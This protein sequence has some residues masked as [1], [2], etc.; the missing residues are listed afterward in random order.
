M[1]RVR[2]R[3][4]SRGESRYRTRSLGGASYLTSRILCDDLAVVLR[5]FPLRSGTAAGGR[6]VV[7]VHG[8]GTSSRYFRPVAAEL[9]K[10]SPVYIVDL[11]GYGS[12]PN[13]RRDVS[14]AD[15]AGVLAR[16]LTAER[17]ENPVLVGHSMGTQVVTRLAFDHPEVT[18]KLVMRGDNDCVSPEAWSREV[19]ALCR[20]GRYAVVR[21]PHVIMYT[22]PVRT[23][24]LIVAH[25]NAGPA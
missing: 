2:R 16:F 21:G 17:I 1:A 13:P 3:F 6:P 20:D 5:R 9:A 15:H 23:A 25:A 7:L 18:D 12:A 8:L 22:D 11:P 14:I 10:H 24:E 19:A 4:A